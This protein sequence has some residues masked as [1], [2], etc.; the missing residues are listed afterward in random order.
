MLVWVASYPRSGNTFFAMLARQCLGIQLD[1]IYNIAET[2][3]RPLFARWETSSELHLVKTHERPHGRSPAIYIIRDGRAA[4]SS[5]RHYL[6]DF[7]RSVFTLEEVI[8]GAGGGTWSDHVKAWMG[9]RAPTLLVRYEYLSQAPATVMTDAAKFLGVPITGSPRVNFQRH[10]ARNPRFFRVGHNG[11]GIEE[12][13]RT[14]SELFWRINGEEMR[15]MGYGD[16]PA[17]PLQPRGC[18]NGIR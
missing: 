13:E 14:C 4:A 8:R 15:R 16:R 10:H 6:E 17:D 1:S 5:Y 7:Q 11:P 18:G 9:G 3:R 12:V 2:A